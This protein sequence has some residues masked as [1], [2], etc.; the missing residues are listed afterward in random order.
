MGIF[1]LLCIDWVKVN[2]HVYNVATQQHISILELIEVVNLNCVEMGILE[3]PMQPIFEE[4]RI[5]DIKHSV[6]NIGKILEEIQWSPTIEFNQGIREL[7][8]QDGVNE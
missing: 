6:A 7:L 2:S 4:S 8:Q 1:K 5:G 3:A